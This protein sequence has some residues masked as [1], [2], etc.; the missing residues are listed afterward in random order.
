MGLTSSSTGFAAAETSLEIKRRS[1]DDRVVAIAGN[2]N[3]GKSTIFNAL[4]GMRQHTGNWPGKTVAAAQ[5][6]CETER[7]GYVLVDIP[8]TYSLLAH[9]AEEEAA[10]DFLCFGGAEAAVVV[11]D[12]AGDYAVS[13]LSGHLGGANRLA[14]AIA[15][16][17][18]GKPV[19][20]TATDV[21]KLMAF[22]ELAARF[23]Y[24]LLNPKAL[25][26]IATAMLD[27]E[28]L[29]L[30]MPPALF[31]NF[32][33][34]NPEFRYQ[35]ASPDGAI[36]VRHAASDT[37]LRLEKLRY[38]VGVGCRRNAPAEEIAAAVD[39]ALETAGLVY[40]DIDCFASIDL[41]QDE[42]GLLEAAKNAGK[43]VRFFTA[44][45]LNRIE[46]PHPS[47]AAREKLGVNSVSEAA[48]LLAAGPGAQLVLDKQIHSQATVAIAEVKS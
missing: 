29:E 18:G 37:V 1:P 28:A 2:P 22:D 14:R 45:E 27:G 38:A 23:R 11:C 9:S 21:R 10:R 48:A 7:S 41:K 31:Q 24:R 36:Q 20:T 44:A 35:G 30:T 47:L 26:R 17:T 19:I 13:L 46:V 43:T 32:Y 12:E 42:A 4:T 16:I 40:D 34:D 6:F 8:G 33:A 39:A 15:G 3:V 5:G 25:V